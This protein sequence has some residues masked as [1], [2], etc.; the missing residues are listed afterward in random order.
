M[1]FPQIQEHDFTL[2][3]LV[4][5]GCLNLGKQGHQQISKSI[6]TTTLMLLIV[7]LLEHQAEVS[8]FSPVMFP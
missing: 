5:L 2:A 7:I 1:V 3:G 4:A 8:P 6:P